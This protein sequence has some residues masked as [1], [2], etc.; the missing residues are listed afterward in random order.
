MNQAELSNALSSIF[1]NLNKPYEAIRYSLEGDA[2]FK[3]PAT[4]VR[5][6]LAD[7]AKESGNSTLAYQ[8]TKAY[9]EDPDFTRDL[10]VTVAASYSWR[11]KAS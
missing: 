3:P 6:V 11:S 10:A 9:D 2:K 1:A 5:K 8:V 7:Y 4:V